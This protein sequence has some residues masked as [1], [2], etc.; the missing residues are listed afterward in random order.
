MAR[1]AIRPFLTEVLLE[2]GRPQLWVTLEGKTTHL[3]DLTALLE[4][5]RGSVLRL[6][7]AWRAVK[8]TPEKDGLRWPGLTLPRAELVPLTQYV[9]PVSE[10][11]RPLLPHLRCH[12]PPLYTVPPADA[13]RL[14]ALLGLKAQEVHQASRALCVPE[15]LAQQRLYDIGI[16]LRHYTS[17]NA[18]LEILRRPWPIAVRLDSPLMSTMQGCLLHGRPDVVERSLVHLLLE[19]L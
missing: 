12:E 2:P 11:Y 9:V 15:S 16:L 3:L 6:P 18:A 14:Q 19:G 8:L 13:G 5:E 17:P 4:T 7:R 10:R 1:A